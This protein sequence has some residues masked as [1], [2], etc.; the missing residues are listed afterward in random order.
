MKSVWGAGFLSLL[1]A[2]VPNYNSH[3]VTVLTISM[4]LADG[5]HV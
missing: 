2:V 4:L 5:L 1:S 3:I